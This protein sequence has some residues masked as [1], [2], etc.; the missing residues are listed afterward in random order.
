VGKSINHT[1][2]V[3]AAVLQIVLFDLLQIRLE[4]A[5]LMQHS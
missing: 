4:E 1:I 5:I 3:S 2:L